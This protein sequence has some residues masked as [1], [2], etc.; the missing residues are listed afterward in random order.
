MKDFLIRK[1]SGVADSP[2]RSSENDEEVGV[3]WCNGVL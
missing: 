2:R 3:V 1:K